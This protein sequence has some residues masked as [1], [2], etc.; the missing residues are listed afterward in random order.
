MVEASLRNIGLDKQHLADLL[1][2][3]KRT[4]Y[5]RLGHPEDFTIS[6]VKRMKEVFGWTKEEL[7]EFI[8]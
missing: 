8:G 2:I 5:R 4:L 3:S 1:N 6:D 7:I